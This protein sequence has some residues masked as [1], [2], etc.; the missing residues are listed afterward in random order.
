MNE[1]TALLR[2]TLIGIPVESMAKKSVWSSTIVRDLFLQAANLW[3]Q[4]VKRV[5]I[6]SEGR[7][8]IMARDF[9]AAG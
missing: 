6:W 9:N 8:M 2:F 3:Q 5:S 7:L 1:S 4:L